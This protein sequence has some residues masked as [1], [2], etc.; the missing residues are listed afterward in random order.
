MSRGRKKE[1]RHNDLSNVKCCNEGC[2]HMIKLRLIMEARERGDGTPQEC[3]H[4]SHPN[5]KV[6]KITNRANLDREKGVKVMKMG[7][8]T[9]A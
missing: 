2:G 7:E 4:C 8:D 3:Y 9:I 5:R 1:F 6:N